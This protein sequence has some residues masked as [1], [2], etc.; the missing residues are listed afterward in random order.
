MN[1]FG[2]N[3]LV[4][5]G[6]AALAGEMSW[7]NV[8]VGFVVGYL[9]LWWIRPGQDATA[10]VRR[11]PRLLTF[12][13]FYLLDVI[14]SSLRIAWDVITPRHRHRPAILAVELTARTD[15][16]ITLLSN[17]LTFSPGS[18]ALDVSDD[19]RVLF[20]HEMF[21]S[22]PEQAKTRMKERME[23]GLLRILK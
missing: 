7:S 16:E 14:N 9:L 19:R 4:A 22:D 6:W 8:I 21:A 12:M 20:V 2:W 18:L 5:L 17:V 10:Y 3:F 11:L 23:A 13:A 15:V 1:T